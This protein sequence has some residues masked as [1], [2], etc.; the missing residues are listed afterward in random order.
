MLTSSDQSTTKI[1]IFI[2]SHYLSRVVRQNI[3]K[4]L[5]NNYSSRKQSL[6]TQYSNVKVRVH[7]TLLNAL[8][9]I[10]IYTLSMSGVVFLKNL[11]L[12]WNQLT[13]CNLIFIPSITLCTKLETKI[14][15]FKPAFLI[16][17]HTSYF[18]SQT[19]NS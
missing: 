18:S 17:V 5:I 1:Y 3:R 7:Q 9:P 2:D 4:F 15:K 16:L 10:I 6:F 13:F 14:L 8:L 19:I 12:N 11:I